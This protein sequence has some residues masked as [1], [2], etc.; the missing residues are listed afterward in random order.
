ML[1]WPG[2]IASRR[3]PGLGSK[4]KLITRISFHT[5]PKMIMDRDLADETKAILLAAAALMAPLLS[6][7]APAHTFTVNSP[8]DVVDAR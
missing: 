2:I 3:R 6:I 7:S 4:E 1:R 5:T 8:A